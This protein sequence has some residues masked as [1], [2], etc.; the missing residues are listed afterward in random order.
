[1]LFFILSGFLMAYLHIGQPFTAAN[2]KQYVLRRSLCDHPLPLYGASVRNARSV[3]LVGHL[4]AK[5][6]SC[7]ILVEYRHNA[8]AV[9]DGNLTVKREGHLADLAFDRPYTRRGGLLGSA[10]SVSW[11][12]S[13]CYAEFA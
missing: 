1:M 2:V 7:F 13:R 10:C 4:Q 11:L 5:E 12:A 9:D 3:L 6:N 8:P